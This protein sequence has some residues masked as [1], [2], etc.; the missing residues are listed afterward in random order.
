MKSSISLTQFPDLIR[1][2]HPTLNERGAAEFT[3]GSKFKAWWICS[4]GHNFQL[5]IKERT[6]RHKSSCP[7]CAKTKISSDYNLAKICPE[8]IREWHPIKNGDLLPENL[9]PSSYREVWWVCPKGHDYLATPNRRSR[10]N[11][12]TG[13]PYCAGTKINAE[14]NLAAR[15]PDLVREWHPT[16]NGGLLPKNLMP[17][18]NKK[19]WWVCPKGHEFFTAVHYRAGQSRSSG[20]PR[21]SRS[22]ATEVNNLAKL[23]PKLIKEEWHPTKNRSL[24]PQDLMPGTRKKVWWKCSHGHSYKSPVKDRTSKNKPTGC[25]YCA[26][27]KVC[28]DNNLA[29]RFPQLAQ[30][31]HNEKNDGISPKQ[32]TPGTHMNA[33]W[34]CSHGHEYAARVWDR[35]VRGASC[36]H[37]N[38]QS[39]RPEKRLFFELKSIFPDII[40][41]HKID[42]FEVDIFLPGIMVAVEYDGSYYHKNKVGKDRV[43]NRAVAR[44][45]VKLIR[46]REAPLKKIALDDII[47]SLKE[48]LGKGQI[49][50]LVAKILPYVEI[51][52][53]KT[54][55]KSYLK[56][57]DFSN[58]REFLKFQS[59][60][61]FPKAPVSISHPQVSALWHP[62]KN[63]T[64]SP[65]N[66]TYGSSEVV[67]WRCP[68]GHSFQARISDRSALR[69]PG[70]C[71]RCVAAQRARAIN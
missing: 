47:V 54:K 10:K 4:A 70:H 60:H 45:G 28:S 38:P 19:V 41:R 55:I 37:C 2:W 59:D 12:P 39:S 11:K 58:E 1:E 14:N 9:M 3:H 5:V 43:K 61:M 16:K 46:V 8:L 44:R 69:N 71:P 21:C 15:Y 62:T 53:V 36:P 7:Y 57:A 50:A 67:W 51:S 25:P 33:W 23:F 27:V 63:K 18:S 29:A 22:R 35:A 56:R 13:C 40:A 42:G 68:E 48:E 17:G 20:C 65:D 49:D 6:R 30:E 24:R 26:G 32:V 31:W 52:K 66:F 64:L 34:R